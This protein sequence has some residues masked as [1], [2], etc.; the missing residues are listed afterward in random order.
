MANEVVETANNAVEVVN[1]KPAFVL[2]NAGDRIIKISIKCR[3]MKTLDGKKE[4]NSVKGLKHLTVIDED[5]VD[6]GKHNRWLDL[7]FT[8]D[9]FKV[10]KQDTR[11]F[12]DIMDLKT[13][14][15]YV[16]AKYIDS[17]KRYEV[18]EDEEPGLL[19][20]PQIWIKGGIGGFEAMVAEQDE[21]ANVL[22]ARDAA[23]EEPEEIEMKVE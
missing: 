13:G 12:D 15:L 11:N 20:Y 23:V 4:F 5:G 3:K 14:F 7:H 1:E 17:P 16:I 10:A 2:S 9:A 19:K 21:C 18:K 8:Q 22:E 6:I